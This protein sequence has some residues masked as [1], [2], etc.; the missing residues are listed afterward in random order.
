MKELIVWTTWFIVIII[1]MFFLGHEIKVA[2]DYRN[3][4]YPTDQT[5][6]YYASDA[7]SYVKW[8]KFVNW[9]CYIKTALYW[10]HVIDSYDT[11]F[12]RDYI[13]AEINPDFK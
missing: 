6:C 10:R 5:I 12:V 13:I 9:K 2:Y 11:S 8:N 7:I 1:W 3:L 4:K